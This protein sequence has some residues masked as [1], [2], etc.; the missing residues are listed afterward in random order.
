MK[1]S[2]WKYSFNNILIFIVGKREPCR[3]SEL[4]RSTRPG[5]VQKLCTSVYRPDP[6]GLLQAD[7]LAGAFTARTEGGALTDPGHHS[8]T[9]LGLEGRQM[10]REGLLEEGTLESSLEGP[11]ALDK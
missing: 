10:F 6:G 8:Q 2:S 4:L 5:Y 7:G 11:G 1:C 3:H 9:Q